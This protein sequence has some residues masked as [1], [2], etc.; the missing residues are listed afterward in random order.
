MSI[1]SE[2]TGKIL[3]LFLFVGFSIYAKAQP[4][5]DNC[6]SAISLGTLPTPGPCIGGLQNGTAV[7]LNNQST[8]GATG[9]N[10]YSYLTGCTG[11][12]NMSAPALDTWYSFTASGTT[13]NINLSGFPQANLGVWTGACGNLSGLSCLTVGGSG[14]GS[15]V[16]TQLQIGQVYYIQISGNNTGTD[17]NFSLSVDND[18]QC[19][20]CLVQSSL[21]ST[22]APNNGTYLPG[23]VVTFC[24]TVSEF[25]EQNTNWFHGVQITMGSGW[26]GVI[27]S[28]VP[29]SDCNYDPTPGPGNAGAGSW[30]YYNSVT[31]T[32]TGQ[33]FGAGF[34][35]DNANIAGTNPGQNFGDPT[36]GNCTWTFCW[37]LTVD[38][39]CTAGADLSVAVNT[40][41]DGESGSWNSIACTG[42]A[43]SSA[44]ASMVC[45]D[46]P[47]TS[48]TNESCP[49]AANGS[50][51]ATG[52]AGTAPYDYVWENSSGNVILTQNNLAN[53]VASTATGL[54]AGTYTV[55][56][57]DANGCE[58]IVDITL[59]TIPCPTPTIAAPP[60]AA[61]YQCIADVPAAPL[62]TW[63][64]ACSGTGTVAAVETN[65][66]ASCPLTITRTWTY[67]NPCGNFATVSQTI[68]VDDTQPPVFS[69]PP[70]AV[71]VQCIGDVPAMTNLAWTDNCDGAGT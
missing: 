1:F 49:G 52:Q 46:I 19:D 70:G 35:F 65:N 36:N 25:S 15:L 61:S 53:G 34:Y 68:T 2:K 48:F 50:A 29:A 42:D 14:S 60:A 24:F 51:S 39:G 5:N 13:A 21:T 18:I 59:T 56:V 37:N 6:A 62:L 7:T 9:E 3:L 47:L 44:S 63:N 23:E 71:T 26:T 12:G 55:T 22:P 57:T 32:A 8:V 28:P 54:V 33:T 66:G 16:I 40:T 31:S 38:P 20:D 17:P 27:S 11:G 43:Q 45:C 69:A 41:G 64:D 4:A 67:T 30:A 58:Q 10:P